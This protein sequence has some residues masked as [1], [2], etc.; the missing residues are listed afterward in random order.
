MVKIKSIFAKSREGVAL[1]AQDQTLEG[2]SPVATGAEASCALLWQ[3]PSP[4]VLPRVVAPF[5]ASSIGDVA[6]AGLTSRL[7]DLPE[8]SHTLAQHS[9]LYCRGCLSVHGLHGSIAMRLGK[10]SSEETPAG[11]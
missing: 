8:D 3:P 4:S 7:N 9:T 2:D 6:N 10:N 5:G 11:T 1:P